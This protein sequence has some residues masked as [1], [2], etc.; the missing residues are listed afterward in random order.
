MP[1]VLLQMLSFQRTSLYGRVAYGYSGRKG[2]AYMRQRVSSRY[3]VREHVSR[4]GV[5]YNG[6]W[7][8][9]RFE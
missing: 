1:A 3:R 2:A 4:R 7:R 5:V 6:Q 8:Y 9:E